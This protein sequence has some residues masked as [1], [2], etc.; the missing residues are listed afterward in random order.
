[1]RATV[2]EHLGALLFRV[3]TLVYEKVAY[4]VSPLIEIVYSSET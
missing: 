1:M 2:Y 3:T 4:E